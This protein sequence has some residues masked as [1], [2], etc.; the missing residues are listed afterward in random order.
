MTVLRGKCSWF[1]GPDD[2]GVSPSEGLAFIYELDDAPDLFLPEAPPG[3]T[4]LARRLDPEEFYIACRWDY[5]VTSKEDLLKLRARVRAP[6]TGKSAIARPADWGPDEDT[7]RVADLSPGLLDYLGITTDDEVEVSRFPSQM[8]A[9]GT[10]VISAGHGLY[11]RG[12]SGPE[13]WGLDEVDEARRMVQRIAT[14]MREMGA[15]VVEFYENEATTQSEN[16]AAIVDEHNSHARQLDI[17]VHF[18]AYNG[19]ANGTEVLYVSQQGLAMDMSEAISKS[20]GFVDRGAKYRS[21]L[22]F[23]NQ[24]IAPAVLVE[25]AFCDSQVDVELYEEKF[26]AICRAIAKT[27]VDFAG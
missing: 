13:P 15:T 5:S 4:G 16:L 23:L 12:A 9:A 8:P 10:I 22:Y 21:D 17:S 27:G 1:G 18:N 20:G 6:K 11:V 19:T 25:T 26:D 3:T 2:E 7:G 14:I 24:T